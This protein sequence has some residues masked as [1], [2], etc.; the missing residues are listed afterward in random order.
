MGF[1]SGFMWLFWILL[2]ILIVWA[3]KSLDKRDKN[4]TKN[5]AALG[6]LEERYARGE[7]DREEFE[8]RKRDLMDT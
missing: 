2:I 3:I 8:Q 1:G 7:I 5:K 4:G 6:I